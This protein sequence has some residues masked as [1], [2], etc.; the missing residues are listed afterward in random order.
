MV[1]LKTA[2]SHLYL[3]GA[4]VKTAQ[5]LKKKKTLIC[6]A[7]ATHMGPDLFGKLCIL[8]ARLCSEL[9]NA[10]N[11]SM[12]RQIYVATVFGYTGSR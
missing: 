5:Q 1:G 9:Q 11:T 12:G 4:L 2:E 10:D 8:G 7:Q 3:P 6:F